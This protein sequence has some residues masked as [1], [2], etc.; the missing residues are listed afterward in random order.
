MD[1]RLDGD[2]L[3]LRV[4]DDGRGLDE[5]GDTEGHGL[6]SMAERARA[7]GGELE[8]R[9]EPGRGATVTLRAPIRRGGWR[10][11]PYAST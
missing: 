2:R 4:A 11:R 3:I 6:R 10:P 5:A 9:S 1:L 8:V 7:L